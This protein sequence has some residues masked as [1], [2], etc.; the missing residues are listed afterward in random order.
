MQGD[1]KPCGPADSE[2]E[3]RERI[4]TNG[5]CE[6]SNGR[7]DTYGPVSYL[8][9]VPGY[10][11]FGWSGKWD[12]LWAAHATSLLFDVLCLV[13]L[14]LVGRRFGG[15]RLAATLAFAWAAYPFTLYVANSNT[16]DAI[17]PAFLIWGFWLA[18][19]P[20]A[21][22]AA[23]ALAG[24]TKFAALLL[25]PLWLTYPEARRA[26]SRRF[27]AGFALATAAAFSVLLLEPSRCTPRASSPSARSAGSS[28]ASR[29]SRSGTGASTTPRRPRPAPRPAGA[30]GPARRRRARSSPSCPGAG[31]RSSSPR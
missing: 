6:S 10:L 22:G 27:V 25:A 12:E 11:A 7:G 1:L 23:V 31:R 4:Q 19:S 3:I 26:P 9:Y 14:A 18:S 24:W 21:R 2:G 29:R 13:G 17:M 5:R 20:W 16:N 15:N 30:P 28:T 8:A